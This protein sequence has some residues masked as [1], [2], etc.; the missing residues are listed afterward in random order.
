MAFGSIFA[1]AGWF[2][3]TVEGHWI[4]GGV[5][6]F[7][8]AVIMLSGLYFVVNSLEVRQT[9][10]GVE[11]I[12]RILGIPVRRRI[13]RRAD[14]VD[15]ETRSSMQSQSNGKHVMHYSVYA[16]DRS[17][18]KL[19]IGEGFRGAGQADAAAR[20][21]G[22][23]FGLIPVGRPVANAAEDEFD[24]LGPDQESLA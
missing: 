12:R 4:F 14:F 6:G 19:I 8:G 1:G 17:R 24:P 3:G 7:V 20:L 23:E 5:F 15:F 2:L 13:M 9:G 16:V 18:R 21:L 22:R 10:D 11:S